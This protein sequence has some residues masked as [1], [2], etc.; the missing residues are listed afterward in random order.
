MDSLDPTLP[1]EEAAK[2]YLD[3]EAPEAKFENMD[4][5]EEASRIFCLRVVQVSASR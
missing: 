5:L 1:F 2:K 4:E 3:T